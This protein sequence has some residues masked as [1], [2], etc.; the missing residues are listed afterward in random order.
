MQATGRLVRLYA[1]K[2]KGYL[3][4]FNFTGTKYMGKHYKQ[5][6]DIYDR[7]FQPEYS[8]GT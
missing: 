4:D 3:H 2:V 5:R 6:L 8:N 1:D 7:N